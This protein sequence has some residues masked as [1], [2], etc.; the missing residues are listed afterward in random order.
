MAFPFGL[1]FQQQQKGGGR[2]WGG[3][4]SY[5]QHETLEADW[6]KWGVMDRETLGMLSGVERE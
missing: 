3:G 6:G 5:E 2:G 1:K 4:V